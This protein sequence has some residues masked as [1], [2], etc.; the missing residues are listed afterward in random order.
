ML[1]AEVMSKWRDIASASPIAG[2]DIS[3]M[4]IGHRT[5]AFQQ[6][7]TQLTNNFRQLLN[8][9][10]GYHILLLPGGGRMQFATVAMNLMGRHAG[11]AD[12]FHTGLWSSFA[13]AEAEKFGAVHCVASAG[14]SHFTRMPDPTTWQLRSEAAYCHFVSNET[15]HGLS[16][17]KISEG[18]PSHYDVPLAV[19]M[20]S[21]LLTRP[22]AIEN[23]GLVYAAAQK[24]CGVTGFTVVIVRDDLI[25]YAPKHTPSVLDYSNYLKDPTPV[26]PV[27]FAI[28]LATEITDWIISKGGLTAMETL[29]I[30]KAS[31]LYAYIDASEKY[32]A[33]VDKAYR[34]TTNVVFTLRDETQTA[35]FLKMSEEEGLIG[36]A[37]H[38][39]VGGVRASLYNAMPEEGVDALIDFM[40]SF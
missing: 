17:P 30:R 33:P 9:P 21:D 25:G 16:F 22:I 39:A 3:F 11:G 32:M 14:D 4:E 15:A 20:T 5:E 26:T 23:Y 28:Y 7:V 24:N 8:V 29:N 1:P 13:M 6:I 27:T 38:R 35:R 2:S 40:Q 18:F 31:K 19:D 36:L 34:S 37:G 10:S 12:Y